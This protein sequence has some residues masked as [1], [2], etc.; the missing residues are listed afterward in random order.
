MTL[1]SL[2][3]KA[4]TDPQ[5]VLRLT[6]CMGW[7]HVRVSGSARGYYLP[8]VPQPRS[9]KG[10]MQI[11][12]SRAPGTCRLLC[13]ASAL[14]QALHHYRGVKQNPPLLQVPRLP[15]IPSPEKQPLSCWLQTRHVDI[16]RLEQK[17]E[18]LCSGFCFKTPG[19]DEVSKG[20]WV[21]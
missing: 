13:G 19:A 16:S 10:G 18:R 11:P 3:A 5:S 9:G 7:S 4:K 20:P 15:S 17:K 8:L 2:A 6:L 1:S 12:V 14:S 21:P